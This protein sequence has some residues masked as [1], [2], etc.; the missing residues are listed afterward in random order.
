M[1]RVS[2]LH[3]RPSGSAITELHTQ[4]QLWWLVYN[5]TLSL[6]MELVYFY[7]YTGI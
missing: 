6:L 2:Y 1:G 5:R 7:K 4:T 3:A